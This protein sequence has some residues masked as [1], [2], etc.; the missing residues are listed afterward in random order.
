[1][2]KTVHSLIWGGLRPIKTRL[3]MDV[4][5]L[6]VLAYC[7]GTPVT[8]PLTAWALV[9]S[10]IVTLL[11]VGLTN[12]WPLSIPVLPVLLLQGGRWL[13][14]A[15]GFTGVWLRLAISISSFSLLALS[16]AL[17]I[18]FPAVELPPVQGPHRV[19]I[20]D[21]FL[22]IAKDDVGQS[23]QNT[24][25]VSSQL[26]KQ[27]HVSVR[28]FYPTHESPTFGI[29]YLKPETAVEFC[30]QMMQFGAPPS[31][32]AFGW[33]LHTWRLARL[34]VK[35]NA[36]LLP[37]SSRADSSQSEP[38]PVVI[39]SHG[40][41]GTCEV[42][43]YQSLQLASHGYV[44][45][46]VNHTDRSAPALQLVDGSTLT[47]DY[48][49]RHLDEK[50]Y[51]R[52]R[53]NRATYRAREVL[54]AASCLSQ[55]NQGYGSID[56]LRQFAGRMKTDRFI[57]MGH[58]FGGATALTASYL[59]PDLVLA[60]VAHEPSSDWLPDETRASLLA[61][62]RSV[63]LKLRYSGGTGGY[64][65]R[66]PIP[67][68]VASKSTIHQH[69]MLFLFSEEWVL[70]KW[71]SILVLRELHD[72]GRL[73][74]PGGVSSFDVILGTQHPEFS[75][76]SMMTPVWLG[77]ASGTCGKRDPCD[78]ALEIAEKTLAFLKAV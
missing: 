24:N 4:A 75:D 35:R 70:Q 56:G 68:P 26:E 59:R 1:M 22:P 74:K 20:V 6:S 23:G 50:E 31:L 38:F 47:Y 51:A 55:V 62:S 28:I 57:F 76:T 8:S 49:I 17:V 77:R 43:A 72:T 15:H 65:D 53:R 32:K 44:V 54:A 5:T 63:G 48:D 7:C 9:G 69:D 39:Q 46:S 11:T 29:P 67:D 3:F 78:T 16:S 40:L 45:V 73:G 14:L 37:S 61:S 21:C 60:V 30:R 25:G 36:S 33:M 52:L 41:G 66:P 13:V 64:M 27:S 18:L 2:G 10:G 71:E 58:S 12:R 19:G 42:Y 34:P